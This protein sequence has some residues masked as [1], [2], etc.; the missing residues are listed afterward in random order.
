MRN[1]LYVHFHPDERA[2]VDRAAEWIDHAANRHEVRRTDFLDP[3]QSHI[4]TVLA[5]REP[6][7]LFRLDGGYQ[8]AERR[9]AIIA[10]A[11]RDIEDEPAGIVVL[12]VSSADQS[13]AQL[14][15]GDYLGAI[16]GLGIKRDRIGDIHVHSD[17]AHFL[18]AEE[19]A[20]YMNINLRQVHRVHVL[21]DILPI[22][23]LRTVKPEL[24][25]M[26]FTV[27]SLRLDGICSDVYRISRAKIVDPIRAGRCR[28]N[29]KAEEDPSTPLKEGD[30]VS[31]QGLGRFKVLT[32]EGVTKKGRIRVR[33]GKF[34]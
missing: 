33:A 22:G 16:L 2:F 29:W 15:H 32:V 13:V 11:Y 12:S 23:Q 27:A 7:A 34:I 18:I 19:V 3:R 1:D 20:D 17:G 25:E 6:D 5:N 30:V 28:V 14:D 21:T 10:P 9:R 4:L 31:I 8:D 26:S 24:E